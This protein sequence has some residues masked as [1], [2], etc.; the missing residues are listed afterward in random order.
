MAVRT[1]AG[2]AGRR[3][4]PRLFEWASRQVVA[5]GGAGRRVGPGGAS[6]QVAWAAVWG[7]D[8][9]S[10]EGRMG[11]RSTIT[12]A[13]TTATATATITTITTIITA[14]TTAAIA[15]TTIIATIITT[16]KDKDEHGDTGKAKGADGD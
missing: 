7:L 8:F 1:A 6:R 14:T 3:V 10:G 5:A 2:G 9:L 12:T 11:K 13:I 15:T 16:T 4:G